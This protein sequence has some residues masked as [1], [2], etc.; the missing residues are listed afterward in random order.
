MRDNRKHDG[1]PKGNF[2]EGFYSDETTVLSTRPD[3]DS[4]IEY[5]TDK[6][7]Q[8]NSFEKRNPG[9]INQVEG[10]DQVYEADQS[11]LVY[12]ENLENLEYF[13]FELDENNKIGMVENYFLKGFELDR[14]PEV[15]R[16]EGL[17]SDIALEVKWM[18]EAEGET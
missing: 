12:S 14:Y 8:S 11:V 1:E 18:L 9:W 4:D 2:L 16:T 17:D 15:K 10:L 5:F 3:Y 7:D 6:L 13:F